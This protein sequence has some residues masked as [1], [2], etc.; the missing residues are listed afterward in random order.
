MNSFILYSEVLSC[1]WPV[2]CPYFASGECRAQPFVRKVKDAYDYYRPTEED[3]REFC[4]T[5][6]RYMG[7]PRRLVYSEHLRLIGLMEHPPHQV[8]SNTR[9]STS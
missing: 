1:D 3:Q 2:N 8:K 6:D 4:N 7:C 9:H 5:K